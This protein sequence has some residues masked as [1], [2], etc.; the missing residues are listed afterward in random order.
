MHGSSCSG[1]S[2]HT[3]GRLGCAPCPSSSERI[4]ALGSRCP[5]ASWSAEGPRPPAAATPTPASSSSR[6]IEACDVLT[7]SWS[8]LW[9][10]PR[11]RAR[12]SARARKSTLAD[13]RWAPPM[14]ASSGESR[15]TTAASASTLAPAAISRSSTF[16]RMRIRVIA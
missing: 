13:G 12:A 10:L 9:P 5:H 14:A 1:R 2:P 4:G 15:R 7:A 8:A 11:Q 3:S 6:T 16:S